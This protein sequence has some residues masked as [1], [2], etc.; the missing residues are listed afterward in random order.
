MKLEEL[1]KG[2]IVAALIVLHLDGELATAAA[3]ILPR[4]SSDARVIAIIPK[5]N[6]AAIV[7][8]MQSSDK[9]AAMLMAENF[10]SR[11]LSAV[12]MRVIAGD[13][14]GLEKMISWGT[15]IHNQLVGD[16]QEK[17]LC[18]SQVSEFAE[19]MGVRRKYREA[20]EQ[21]I[22]EM[23]MNALYDAPVDEQGKPL[24]SEIP[25][26]TRI[27]LRV[28]QKIVV[29][30][31]CDGKQFAVS[32]RDAFG[33]LER[34]TV[35][36][37]L[38]KCLHSE[39]QIDRKVGGAGL[40]LYLMV[41][42]ATSVFFNVLP[43]VA[44]EAV[45]VF[46][47]EAPKIQ[48]ERFGFFN[49]KIDAGGRLAA[50]ASRRL[51]QGHPVE[52][53]RSPAPPPPPPRG[54]IAALSLA[55]LAV[56]VLVGIAAWPRL[57]PAM[58][59]AKV[60]FTTIPKGATIEIEGRNEGTATDG[61]LERE[62]EVGRAYPV[63][64]RLD[65]YEP[66]TSVVQPQKG[67]SHVTFELVARTATVFLDTQPTGAN[68]E[69]DGKSL[70][71]TPLSITTLAPSTSVQ[72][73][74]K[75]TGYHPATGTL[76]VPGPGKEVRMV[77]PL[78]VSDELARIKL[79]S[80]PLGAQV[81]QNGQ[82][83]AG[84]QTPAEVLVEAGKVQRFMLTMPNM[85]PAFIDPFTPGRGAVGV[86]K[87]GKLVPGQRLRL[88]ATNDGK[89]SVTGAQHCKELTPPAECILAPGTYTVDYN[90]PPSK[91]THQV[92]VGTKPATD[93]FELGFVEAAEGKHLMVGGKQVKKALFEAGPRTVTLA[94]DSGTKQVQVKVKAG[95]TVIA[96]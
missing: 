66:K 76:D 94:D 89:L 32:V 45:C 15:L 28:E 26:K 40:G 61:T 39:Q 60:T 21:C 82:L 86:V 27:S 20:I 34:N 53:R 1:A 91:F 36:R 10:D 56:L 64:A 38:Y 22:D 24:F 83:L 3:E 78:A 2:E 18:I 25:T 54:L 69:V 65:G 63:V 43:G 11:Q 74:I 84:V 57:F 44:T 90:V 77:M 70:G 75:K 46:D 55:I 8:I 31:A 4:L 41:N 62:L 29:Q 81:Y 67:G 7:D 95:A 37:Y 9:I 52:R 68:V 48:L 14:F 49:E 88:D 80:D 30:Y 85:V 71:T 47:L 17:S 73:T 16:Y 58:Q 50:G 96:K 51:P 35:L 5:S 87:T 6:L 12:A 42:S 92:T 19:L 33:T 13:I 72:Y 93:R 23:L 79:V 59:T